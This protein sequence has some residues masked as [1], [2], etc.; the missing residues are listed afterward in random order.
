MKATVHNWHRSA[1]NWLRPVYKWLCHFW[2][3]LIELALAYG[4]TVILY[5]GLLYLA[6]FLWILYIETPVGQKFLEYHNIE[7]IEDLQQQNFLVL[8][9]RITFFAISGCLTL[10]AVSQILLIKRYF[11]DPQGFFGRLIYWGI[12]CTAL[13]SFAIHRILKLEWAASF[14]LALVPSLVLFN[15][16]FRFTE[17]VPEI[18]ALF[19]SIVSLT[20]EALKWYPN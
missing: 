17:L 13:T 14:S 5:A 7:V 4:A 3:K 12:P 18:S 11:Y 10:G 8:I 19:K 20:K 2:G 16:C 9:L 1:H 15:Y 6:N